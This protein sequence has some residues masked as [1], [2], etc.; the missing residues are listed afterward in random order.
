MIC[1]GQHIYWV[2]L[3]GN[4]FLT[5]KEVSQILQS[6]KNH[7]ESLTQTIWEWSKSNERNRPA[8][9]DVVVVVAVAVLRRTTK[10]ELWRK[11]GKKI[12]NS[13]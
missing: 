9:T 1:L 8:S 10:T 12:W 7:E 11:Y 5:T 6:E 4:F 13:T 2:E 3:F